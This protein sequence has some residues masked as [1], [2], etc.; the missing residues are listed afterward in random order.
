MGSSRGLL[1]WVLVP[2]CRGVPISENS[3]SRE[4]SGSGSMAM[5]VVAGT[6]ATRQAL[7]G[8]DPQYRGGGHVGVGTE[9]DAHTDGGSGLRGHEADQA[10]AMRSRN[11]LRR[12]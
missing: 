5:A 7:C 11:S 12:T 6:T 4:V 2:N 10:A 1:V 3:C 9:A 8:G